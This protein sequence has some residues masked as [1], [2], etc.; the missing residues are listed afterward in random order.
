MLLH[1]S[2]DLL[3]YLHKVLENQKSTKMIG[4]I[5][6]VDTEKVYIFFCCYTIY[7]ILQN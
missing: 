2:V 4:I 7:S 1:F 6:I 3:K 5:P